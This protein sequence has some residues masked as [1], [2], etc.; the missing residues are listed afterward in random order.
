[1]RPRT[2]V[3]VLAALAATAA[4]CR[5]TPPP[6]PVTFDRDIAPIVFSNCAPCHR[7]GEAAPFTLLSYADLV[8]HAD[9]VV[10]ETSKHHM[11]P[12]PP[13]PGEF[14]IA[15][16]RRLRQDQIDAFQ[17]WV[18]GGMKEGNPADLPPR[19]SWPEGWQYGVPDVVLTPERAYTLRPG[20][21][22]VYRNLIL[23]SPLKA[24]VYVRAVE[25]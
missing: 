10:K 17:S 21:E 16:E 11:P 20:A 18:N 6:S 19:P 9:G 8:K 13:E 23:H 12:W 2:L 24:A 22:D 5:N 1:M 3:G 25:F 15:G 4:A 14:P 7:P